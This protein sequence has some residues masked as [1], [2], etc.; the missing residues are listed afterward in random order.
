VN[1]SGVADAFGILRAAVAAADP[2]ERVRQTLLAAPELNR[3]DRV[4]VVAVGKAACRMAAAAE[5][6]LR[7]RIAA[8]IVIVPFGSTCA[9]ALH[10]AHPVPDASSEAAARALVATID[11]TPRDALLLVLLSG[12]ASSLIALPAAGIAIADYARCVM[13]LQRAGADIGELNTVRKHI[14]LLKGGRLAVLAAPRNVLGLI[15]S[16]VVGDPIDVIASGP[17]TADPTTFDSAIAVL[18]RRGVWEHCAESIRATLLR[19]A[20]GLDNETPKQPAALQHVRTSVIGGNAL[21]R[22]G[23]AAAAR[24]LGYRELIVNDAL[25][26][27]ARAAAAWLAACARQWQ[28]ILAPG[29]VPLCLIAGGETTVTVRG[30][31]RGGRNQ[32]LVLAAALALGNTPG[33][34]VG[35]AATDGID[36]DSEAAGAVANAASITAARQRGIDPDALLADNDSNGFFRATAGL[37]VTGPTGTNVMDVQIALVQ[38]AAL[39]ES[40]SKTTR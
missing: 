21:A 20:A 2:A 38:P 14:D 13:L 32:E 33:I 37:L 30:R 15:L 18:R 10:A 7:T 17:L 26:G 22:D 27:E 23:A 8:R 34:V 4:H 11:R 28:T 36:G 35:A 5:D 39:L 12:G 19:G 3:A 6:V 25:T 29:D 16:D 9:A 1:R 40:T 31:G 24:R